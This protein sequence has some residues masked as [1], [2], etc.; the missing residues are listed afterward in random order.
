[1]AVYGSQHRDYSTDAPEALYSAR[2]KCLRRIDGLPNKTHKNILPEL[3]VV[4]PIHVHFHKRLT[5][6]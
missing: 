3:W 2:G 4:E 6:L 5:N 1:M